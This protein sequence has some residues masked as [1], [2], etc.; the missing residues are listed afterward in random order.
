MPCPYKTCTGLITAFLSMYYIA[1]T[2]EDASSSSSK[3]EDDKPASS[4]KKMDLR[5]TIT[6]A[7]LVLFHIDLF[8]TGYV[9]LGVKQLM[10]VA[11]E[12]GGGVA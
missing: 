12:T 9:R 8:T 1:S 5:R 6:I 3:K 10:A 7:L 4:P 2:A 11:T